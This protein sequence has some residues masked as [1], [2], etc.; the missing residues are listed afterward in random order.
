MDE[1]NELFEINQ[2]SDFALSYS[3]LSDFDRN[4][5]KA[6]NKQRSQLTG[7]GVKIGSLVD[8]LLLNKSN[9][10]KLYYLYDGVKPT[11]TLGKLCDIVIQNY[12]R[13]PSKK[14]LLKIAKK[15]K[16]WSKWSEE[17][18]LQAFDIPE[19]WDY[20]KA[21]FTSKRKT[22]VTTPDIELS[23]ELVNIL[24]THEYSKYIITNS[25]KHYNQFKFNIE[26]KGFILRGIID[27]VLVDHKTKTVR[28]ID[29]KTG[30]GDSNEFVSSFLKWRYYLQAAVYVR[31]FKEVCKTLKLIDYTLLP[32]QFLYIGRS[33]KL[34][35]VF[36]VT[37]RWQK[38]AAYGFTTTAGYTYRGL[39]ELLDLVRWHIDNKVFDMTRTVYESNGS[40]LLDDNLISLRDN[41]NNY[42]LND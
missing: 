13:P 41:K 37:K 31:A 9:F 20:I 33:E 30:K 6:L 14:T 4:G 36:T 12:K 5:A 35:I 3:R 17:K 21:S 16:F 18:V 38:A 24:E 29:L 28:F 8:D 26:Y 7:E 27:K 25:M 40:I 22:L 42:K 1:L 11:A 10:K 2:I 34:P 23:N 19:F 39:Y 15:N 32:F